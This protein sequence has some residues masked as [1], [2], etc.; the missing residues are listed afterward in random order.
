VGGESGCDRVRL[1]G[2]REGKEIKKVK[3]NQEAEEVEG[4]GLGVVA[5]S[6]GID[7]WLK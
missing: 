5:A 2:S 7:L 4:R 3:A 6:A 1:L